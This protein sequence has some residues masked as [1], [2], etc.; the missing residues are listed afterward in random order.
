MKYSFRLAA[1]SVCS[2]LAATA[3]AGI[4]DYGEPNRYDHRIDR[5]G[6]QLSGYRGHD[7]DSHYAR[8]DDYLRR[9]QYPDF[10]TDYGHSLSPRYDNTRCNS[11]YNQTRR[12]QS[13]YATNGYSTRR[14]YYPTNGYNRSPYSGGLLGLLTGRGRGIN[15]YYGR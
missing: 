11:G 5:S 14:N 6:H 10:R 4:Y 12:L 3:S 15:G 2:L 13:G 9:G 8:T 1:F 7:Y